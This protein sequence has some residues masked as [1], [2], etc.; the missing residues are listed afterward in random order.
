MFW[1]EAV[2]IVTSRLFRYYISL[3]N[4]FILNWKEFDKTVKSICPVTFE[5]N[6]S[7]ENN[8]VSTSIQLLFRD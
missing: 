7:I 1:Q 2:E 4:I 3:K 8:R 5:Q 6:G